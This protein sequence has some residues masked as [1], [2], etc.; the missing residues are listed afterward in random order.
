M[1]FHPEKCVVIQVTNKRNPI[2][3]NYTIHGHR[4]DVVDSSKYLGV[5]ISK[6][7]R[8]DNH[9]NNVTAKANKTLGFI[10]RN[11]RG[12]RTSARSAA[13]QGLV[14]PTLE[15]AC[16]AW[17]PWNSKH[18]QQ[19]EKVQRRAARLSTRNYHDRHPG[20]VIQMIEDLHWE[21]L[22][23]RRL[24]IRLVL[25]YK[26]QYALVAIPAELH[27]T[28]SDRRTRGSHTFRLP[29]TRID[30]HRYS[31]FPRTIGDWNQLSSEVAGATSLDS[32]KSQ[33]DTYTRSPLTSTINN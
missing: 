23:T 19:L 26:I 16:A 10:R 7:L 25:L 31:F 4:L 20:S 13:Y 28:T 24:K 3:A 29:Q 22:Q 5:T 12:C 33:L 8:W 18:I 1:A 17:D 14:R 15:Y 6:D 30:A 2:T 32:F 9:I 27:L 11:M 21:P